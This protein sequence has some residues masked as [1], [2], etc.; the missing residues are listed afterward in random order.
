MTTESK[1]PWGP[2]EKAAWLKRQDTK[3]S[4][5]RI[6]ANRLDRLPTNGLYKVEEYG[7][8]N[9]KPQPYRLLR[10]TV[11]DLTN[12]KPNVLITGG[13]HGYEMS[14]VLAPM[15]FLEK[16]ASAL[17]DR[18]NFLVYPCLSPWAMEVDHRW[19]PDAMDTNRHFKRD[20]EQTAE[21]VAFMDSIESLKTR[22][23]VAVDLHETNNRD[24]ELEAE[25]ADKD[26]DE[27]D[28]SPI[29]QGFYLVMHSKN[30]GSAIG[31]RIIETVSKV[32]R[33]APE[34]DF[35]GMTNDGGLTFYD[36]PG[37]CMAFALQHAPEA[38]TTEVYPDIIT[39]EE[40]I[41][42]QVASIRGALEHVLLEP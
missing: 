32:T 9:Y 26:G 27:P 11:G 35:F 19:N 13:V 24:I 3:R 5:V 10:V 15:E 12:G 17:S 36:K 21:C 23:R 22:F 29:P 20:G 40:A 30:K 4:Y 41:Q 33:I 16:Y 34:K 31:R 2:E 8:L 28:T 18:F 38:V 25:R 37:L 39:Q 42:G 14:G 7:S 1:K 6:V